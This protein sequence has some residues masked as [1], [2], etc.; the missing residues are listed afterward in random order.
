MSTPLLK[1]E[2]M[3]KAGEIK[4]PE[5]YDELMAV[6][7]RYKYVVEHEF[8]VDEEVEHFKVLFLNMHRVKSGSKKYCY[9]SAIKQGVMTKKFRLLSD[10][11]LALHGVDLMTYAIQRLIIDEKIAL[12]SRKV[13]LTSK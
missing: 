5:S 6:L 11:I 9:I 13:F 10:V 8:D 7:S 4:F 2:E 12:S 1:F 3:L